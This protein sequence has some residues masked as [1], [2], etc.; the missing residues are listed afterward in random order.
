MKYNFETRDATHIQ[1]SRSNM[2]ARMAALG[3]SFNFGKPP[4]QAIRRNTDDG[5]SAGAPIQIR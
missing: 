1:N 3:F 2:K 4:E 5:S